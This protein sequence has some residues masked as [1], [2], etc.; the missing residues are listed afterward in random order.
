MLYTHKLTIA[1][2]CG[3]EQVY[4]CVENEDGSYTLEGGR[5]FRNVW[6]LLN[7]AGRNS[8]LEEL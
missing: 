2:H 4:L 1:F 5:K 8:W 7:W 6:H 3:D